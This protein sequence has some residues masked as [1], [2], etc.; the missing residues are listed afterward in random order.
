MAGGRRKREDQKALLLAS[1][2]D[3]FETPSDLPIFI[4]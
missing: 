2:K 3:P 1:P 4:A